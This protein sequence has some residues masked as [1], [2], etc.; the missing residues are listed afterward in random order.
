[1]I[2]AGAPGTNNRSASGDPCAAWIVA[3]ASGPSPVDGCKA[4]AIESDKALHPASP[5]ELRTPGGQ[6]FLE[7]S[8][9][10]LGRLIPRVQSERQPALIERLA[11][12]AHR[13]K[14]PRDMQIE[15]CP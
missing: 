8:F 6:V 15:S 5:L 10:R 9:Q 12:T 3:F 2:C 7:F 13:M 4:A 11:V 1:L 14:R